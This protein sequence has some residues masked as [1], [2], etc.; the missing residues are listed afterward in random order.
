MKHSPGQKAFFSDA[1]VKAL[2]RQRN[3]RSMRSYAP[4]IM[5]ESDGPI[6]PE[7]VGQYYEMQRRYW[8]IPVLVVSH[9]PASHE[10]IIQHIDIEEV[11]I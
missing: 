3:E 11:K 9:S 10:H 8:D 6:Q 1:Y 2:V 4:V 5:D 7:L